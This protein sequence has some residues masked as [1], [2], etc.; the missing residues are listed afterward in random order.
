LEY[1]SHPLVRL[2]EM[3]R[4]EPVEYEKLMLQA[5]VI[6]PIY[7][8][9][10]GRYFQPID[11]DKA[12]LYLEK[13]MKLHPDAVTASHNA[14][15]LITYYQQHGQ[16]NKA[17]ALADEAADTYSQAG[18]E[19]KAHFLESQ[20]K[21]T[22]AYD[23]YSKIEVRYNNSREL[24]AFL[25]RYRAKTG[26]RDFDQ[27]LAKRL[28]TLF[29]NGIEKVTLS[30]LHDP[31]QDGVKINDTNALL[32]QA[33]LQSGDIIV[34]LEGIRVHNFEQYGY[35]RETSS[36]SEMDL[37]IWRDSQYQQVTASPP[38]H[39]FNANFATWSASAQGGK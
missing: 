11:E 7:Y 8:Y 23:Y 17:A 25:M 24:M 35:A 29:P 14:D 1:N 19:A 38:S 2:A 36:T 22:E 27:E 37:L 39:R 18:L 6:A 31:P 16:T 26:G 13:G 4:A 15:W 20:G 28:K 10:L 3:R 32:R 30:Q 12:A 21:Y 5:A 33:G 34:A 9:R